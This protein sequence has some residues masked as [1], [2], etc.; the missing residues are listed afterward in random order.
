MS[1]NVVLPD[2]EF[3]RDVT[4]VAKARGI[5]LEAAEAVLKADGKRR[6][7]DGSADAESTVA[8]NTPIPKL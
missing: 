8:L 1:E 3:N 6:A 4:T 2:D 7:S 5:S